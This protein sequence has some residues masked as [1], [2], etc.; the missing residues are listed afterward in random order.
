MLDSA[1]ISHIFFHSLYGNNLYCLPKTEPKPS[2][3][4]NPG[5]KFILLL[6]KDGTGDTATIIPL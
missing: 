1:V 2:D 5:F 6:M 4:Q 3:Q